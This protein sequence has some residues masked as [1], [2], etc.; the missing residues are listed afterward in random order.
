MKENPVGGNRY[1]IDDVGSASAAAIN[2]LLTELERGMLSVQKKKPSENHPHTSKQ[3]M[4]LLIISALVNH[5]RPT[6]FGC[7]I[8]ES[9][10]GVREFS[11]EHHFSSASLSSF[12][13]KEFGGFKEYQALCLRETRKLSVQLQVLDGTL[14]TKEFFDHLQE[15]KQKIEGAE[16]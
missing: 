3:S 11:K 4:R 10:P 6:H 15:L 1:W 2:D 14:P 7:E 5:H 13:K 12:L 16:D 9:I 8:T